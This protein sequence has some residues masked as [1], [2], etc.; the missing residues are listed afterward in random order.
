MALNFFD[1]IQALVVTWSRG[2]F[3]V[4]I[5]GSMEITLI[6]FNKLIYIYIVIN[7]L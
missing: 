2:A 7:I 3:G 6:T 5:D 1:I 4:F